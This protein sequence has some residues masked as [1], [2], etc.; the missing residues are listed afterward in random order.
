M[1]ELKELG[2]EPKGLWKVWS[3]FPRRWMAVPCWKLG[4]P[5]CSIT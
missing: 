2:V 3:I 5:K 4:E 1:N